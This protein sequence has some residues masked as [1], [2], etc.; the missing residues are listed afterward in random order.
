MDN[1]KHYTQKEIET[2]IN[3]YNNT[4]KIVIKRN[5]Q[6]IIT[7]C[8]YSYRDLAKLTGISEQTLYQ[9]NKNYVSNYPNFL[10]ALKIANF[11]EIDITEFIKEFH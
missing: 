6:R 4:N 11:L 2:L 7:E 5:A 9:Y 10:T 1:L 8:K 3:Q